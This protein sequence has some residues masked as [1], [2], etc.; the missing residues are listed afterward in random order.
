MPLGTLASLALALLI[1]L[2]TWHHLAGDEAG[3]AQTN[4]TPITVAAPV[5]ASVSQPRRLPSVT[6]SAASIASRTTSFATLA[7]ARQRMWFP[8]RT[9]TRGPADLV[10][11]GIS[12]VQ[13]GFI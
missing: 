6:L 3:V 11:Q 2:V 10:L 12:W 13:D 8:F 5:A 7:D 9:L 1:C 4:G